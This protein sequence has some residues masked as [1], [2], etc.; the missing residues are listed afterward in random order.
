MSF[1]TPL[2]HSPVWIFLR[3]ILFSCTLLQL[4]TPASAAEEAGADLEEQATDRSAIYRAIKTDLE[5]ILGNSRPAYWENL[6]KR[7]A[8]IKGRESLRLALDRM[9]EE[10]ASGRYLVHAEYYL[11]K[12]PPADDFT[13]VYW[14]LLSH[15]E[16]AERTR[17]KDAIFPKVAALGERIP[18]EDANF[19][20]CR[21]TTAVHHLYW[22]EPVLALAVLQSLAQDPRL[23]DAFSPVLSLRTGQALEGL[24][25]WQEALATYSPLSQNRDTPAA[26]SATI[27]LLFL[28]LHEDRVQEAEEILGQLSATNLE[29]LAQVPGGPQVSAML[30]LREQEELDAMWEFRK[31]WRPDF[32][33]FLEALGISAP[34]ADRIL[35]LPIIE[36]VDKFLAR[37]DQLAEAPDPEGFA[38]GLRTAA[39]AASWDP[40]SFNNLMRTLLFGVPEVSPRNTA[41]AR[42][43]VAAA[44]RDFRFGRPRDRHSTA[45]YQCL[46]LLQMERDKEALV[47][48]MA[49]CE[50]ME[51]PPAN[52][53]GQ[54]LLRLWAAAARRTSSDV[55]APGRALEDLLESSLTVFDRLATVD[56]LARL[57]QYIGEPE[58]EEGL[59]Q[60]ELAKPTYKSDRNALQKLVERYRAS[61]QRGKEGRM[62][63][64]SSAQ[65]MREKAPRWLQFSR[66]FSIDNV[67]N[68]ELSKLLESPS[69]TFSFLEG[70]KLRLLATKDSSLPVVERIRA[71]QAAV[72]T[73]AASANDF[74]FQQQIYADLI[75]ETS[76]PEPQRTYFAWLAIANAA[77]SDHKPTVRKLLASPLLENPGDIIADAL[78]GIRRLLGCN[79]MD[80]QSIRDTIRGLAEGPVGAYDLLA[81]NALTTRLLDLGAADEAREVQASIPQWELSDGTGQ[82]RVQMS[83][84][85]GGMIKEFLRR[86][87][88]NHRLGR[89]ALEIFPDCGHERPDFS[90]RIELGT[91][92]PN[93]LTDAQSREVLLYQIRHGL[94]HNWSHTIWLELCDQI[95]HPTPDDM[96]DRKFAI[97][98]ELLASLP[99][100]D[101]ARAVIISDLGGLFDI[102]SPPERQRVKE[103]IAAYGTDPKNAP[104]SAFATAIYGILAE[105]REGRAVDA[106]TWLK[107]IDHPGRET[108]LIRHHLEDGI[109]SGNKELLTDILNSLD[110]EEDLS[111]SVLLPLI[112]QAHNTLEGAIP[113]EL[114]AALGKVRDSLLVYSVATGDVGAI[115]QALQA[116]RILGDVRSLPD[117]WF[118]EFSTRCRRKRQL[119]M[120]ESHLAEQ[121]EDWASLKKLSQQGIADYPT[122]YDFYRFHG[123]AMAEHG[124]TE[125]AIQSLQTYCRYS[126]NEL[127]Y[128]PAKVLLEKLKASRNGS[129]T[130]APEPE[131]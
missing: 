94:H 43:L 46:A 45:L 73:I 24:G 23:P 106:D 115:Y 57:Y 84:E 103:L 91:T 9:D 79:R 22:G 54:A 88:R 107:G 14:R 90:Y 60:R 131:S 104:A 92:P 118:E 81:I 44:C 74:G 101:A 108:Y 59:L 52:A 47:V 102:D 50:A 34:D 105:Q 95:P 36:S 89:I 21:F 69:P 112:C 97:V 48:A 129:S 75:A 55:L 58:A 93:W 27:R 29:S 123:I 67:D 96:L 65:W 19:Y 56:A 6:G 68:E 7:D 40:V 18:L 78:A 32:D 25:R 120:S 17:P 122:Y 76:F 10:G 26:L 66:P 11:T 62:L 80:K 87:E 5:G 51:N 63:T 99:K 1:C 53:P 20:E 2:R 13:H 28:Y 86:S 109:R 128:P 35:A 61:T 31:S 4:G 125:Q 38:E 113:S 111:E 114:V 85:I 130:P 3:A 82:N 39:D 41:T 126:K 117:G 121:L 15:L 124:N 8:T 98:A 116:T 83:L 127:E 70:A 42:N 119:I 100:D 16:W 33:I 72:E 49:E 37:L 30:V 77:Y 71:F 12:M 64:R 110:D